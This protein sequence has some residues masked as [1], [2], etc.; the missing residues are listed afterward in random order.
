MEIREKVLR[1]L[2]IL[3]TFIMLAWTTTMESPGLSYRLDFK[4]CLHWTVRN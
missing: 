1:A 4:A 2:R 3:L